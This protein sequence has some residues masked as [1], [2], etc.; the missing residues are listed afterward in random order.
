MQAPEITYAMGIAPP[1]QITYLFYHKI[2]KRQVFCLM[3]AICNLKWVGKVPKSDVSHSP[4]RGILRSERS[5]GQIKVKKIK[6]EKKR[7]LARKQEIIAD[8]VK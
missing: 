8:F 2:S 7:D 4:A 6:S 5:E 3:L 1:I